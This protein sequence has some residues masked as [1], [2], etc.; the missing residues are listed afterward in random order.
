MPLA[1]QVSDGDLPSVNGFVYMGC[2]A[3][4]TTYH[5]DGVGTMDSG[6]YSKM[7]WHHVIIFPELPHETIQQ[8]IDM[9][10]T[11][12]GNKRTENI[13]YELDEYINDRKKGEV[14]NNGML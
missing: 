12:D 6:H 9:I 7:G 10:S 3:G 8:A 4:I 1:S 2:G 11:T 5:R 13:S 14:R